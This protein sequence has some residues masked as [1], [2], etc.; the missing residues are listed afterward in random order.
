MPGKIN[1]DKENAYPGPCD[2]SPETKSIFR[3]SE[4]ISMSHKFKTQPTDKSPGPSD[5]IIFL[6]QVQYHSYLQ[7]LATVFDWKRKEKSLNPFYIP[8]TWCLWSC[9]SK[10][11]PEFFI[12]RK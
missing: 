12:K 4:K 10:N 7:K 3:Q 5:V 11:K 6:T 1:R 9:E 8:R 2:Y